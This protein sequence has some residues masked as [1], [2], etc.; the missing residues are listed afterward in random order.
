M[1]GLSGVDSI[2][3]EILKGFDYV[4]LGHI[5]KPQ[6]IGE[7][8]YY[9]GSPLPLR[10][11]ETA[12][13]SVVII[14]EENGKISSKPLLI[15]V[16]RNLFM[17]KTSE[18]NFREDL[19]RLEGQA[20]LTPMVEVQIELTS[21]RV[22]LVDEVKDILSNKGMELLSF[23]PIYQIS[24]K[25]E[26]RGEKIFE[27]SP[28]ELFEEFYATKYPEAKSLPADLVEDFKSLLDKVKHAS[29]LS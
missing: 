25:K 18:S 27:L 3:T 23:L 22:G 19:A 14:E 28:L 26:R 8:S 5:H 17:V 16:F 29:H 2:P 7:N 6:R 24:E 12:P 13:K 10:F 1:I 21:P 15:P 4:A 9:S 11:S 20:D